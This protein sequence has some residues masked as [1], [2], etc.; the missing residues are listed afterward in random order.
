MAGAFMILLIAAPEQT[1]GV[2]ERVGVIGPSGARTSAAPTTPL[3][4][5]KPLIEACRRQP[6]M[7]AATAKAAAGA[8][9]GRGIGADAERRP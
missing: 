2:L 5:A 1:V 8:L 6:E 4:G 9:I 3:D 7:C